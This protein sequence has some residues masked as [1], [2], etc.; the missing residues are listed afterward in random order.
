MIVFDRQKRKHKYVC[1]YV[2]LLSIRKGRSVETVNSVG[3]DLEIWVIIEDLPQVGL[4][5]INE[6]IKGHEH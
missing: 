6:C 2:L 4:I 1:I 3:N 5:E